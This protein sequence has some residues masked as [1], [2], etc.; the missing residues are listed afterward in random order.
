[1]TI[2]FNTLAELPDE[3]IVLHPDIR[4][5]PPLT[6]APWIAAE[7]AWTLGGKLIRWE[8][9][10]KAVD[11]DLISG[12]DWGWISRA[13]LDAVAATIA[14]GASFGLNYHGTVMTVEWRTHDQPCLEW[15]EA[16]PIRGS[17]VDAADQ[18][19]ELRMK[20]IWRSE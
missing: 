2:T 3:P 15:E 20:L 18:I 6:A 5:E 1:M 16:R 9:Q 11:I 8:K 7:T 10:R 12:E 14:P 17:D 19:A 4:T 13:T